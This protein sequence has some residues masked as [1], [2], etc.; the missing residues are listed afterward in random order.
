MACSAKGLLSTSCSPP[1]EPPGKAILSIHYTPRGSSFHDTAEP[2]V[3]DRIA[4]CKRL[5][6]SIGSVE[7]VNINQL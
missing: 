6:V 1:S 5:K 4:A 3:L 2:E 7:D